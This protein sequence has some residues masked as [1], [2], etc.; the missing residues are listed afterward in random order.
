MRRHGRD[1]NLATEARVTRLRS[2]RAL[3]NDRP[4]IRVHLPPGFLPE[5]RYA[6]EVLLGHFLGFSVVF[7]EPGSTTDWCIDLPNGARLV[8]RDAFF[9]RL[10]NTGYLD[11]ANIPAAVE[12]MRHDLSGDSELP[13]LFGQGGL[14]LGPSEARLEADVFAAAFFMLTRWEECVIPDRDAH[15]RFP[16]RASL[17]ARAG[18]LGT[19]IVD[20]WV[21][22]LKG[23]LDALGCPPPRAPTFSMLHTHDIDEPVT[24]WSSKDA[25]RGAVSVIAKGGKLR[26]GL[27]YLGMASKLAQDPLDTFE[28]MMTYSEQQGL[29]ATFY[30]LAEG[31]SRH[32]VSYSLAHPYVVRILERIRVRGHA[33]GL[34]AGYDTLDDPSALRAQR[35]CLERHWGAPIVE[36]RQH[37]LRFNAPLTWRHLEEAGVAVDSTCGYVDHEGFRCGTG[38]PYPVFDVLARRPVRVIERPI[39]VSDATLSLYRNLPLEAA[40]ESFRSLDRAARRWGSGFTTLIHNSFVRYPAVS[41][42]Y[43]TFMNDLRSP[44]SAT[45]PR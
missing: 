32:D 35:D 24:F 15:G 37:Y 31:R 12:L 23:V 26:Q 8:V 36:S 19:P 1:A 33:L 29:R 25:L 5:R 45:R 20:G 6:V 17:A 41:T 9:G 21:Q 3:M 11:A 27:R 40:L 38:T 42:A 14:S 4:E 13:V 16:A 22:L 30:A 44:A 39:I 18:F 43:R 10:V 2:F 7:L 28:E 34:H